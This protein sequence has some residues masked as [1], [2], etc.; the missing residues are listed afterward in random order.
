M[1]DQIPLFTFTWDIPRTPYN[2]EDFP[3]F[4]FSFPED[5]TA[6]L[7]SD[8]LLDGTQHFIRLLPPS[9]YARNHFFYL[10]S[11]VLLSCKSAY[12]TKRQKYDSYLL[13]YTY[14]GEGLLEY[15]GKEY[16]LQQN[17]GFLIDCKEPHFYRS[18]AQVWKHSDIHFN[19]IS[20]DYLFKLWSQSGDVSFFT[21]C[22]N[23]FQPILEHLLYDYIH[24]S[25][26]REM[27]VSNHLETLLLAILQEK[28]TQN[29][30]SA[31]PDTLR[32]LI[33]YME[34]NFSN[35]LTLDSLAKFAG[36]SKYHLC[37]EFKRYIG[38]S[39]IDY[40]ISLRIAHAKLLLRNTEI[41][42]YKAGQLS[43]IED[44]NNFTRLFKKETG[45]TP[46]EYR[47]NGIINNDFHY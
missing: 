10:Q 20:A 12:F 30:S 34:S 42:A 38:N 8:F 11:F 29:K 47:N 31:I 41:P 7:D 15:R 43:G 35:P 36:L 17:T 19:G 9:D 16:L 26:Q 27:L 4:S 21:T 32:Y 1:F 14:E 28:N 44:H 18:N 5:C 3:D 6:A 23:Y 33:K 46:T 2:K 37:R 39:P 24:F 40:L 25:P 13:L 45:M 22:D